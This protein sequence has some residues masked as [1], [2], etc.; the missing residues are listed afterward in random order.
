[1]SRIK[2]QLTAVKQYADTVVIEV[3]EPTGISLEVL[4]FG[5]ESLRNGVGNTVLAVSQKSWQMTLEHAGYFDYRLKSG[6]S[7]P[8]VP[9]IK[10]IFGGPFVHEVPEEREVLIDCPSS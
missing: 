3:S 6:M 4:D 8:V 2:I 1:M 7:G 9:T 10:E 5:I